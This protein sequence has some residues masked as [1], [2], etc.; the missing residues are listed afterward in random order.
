MK[1][2]FTLFFDQLQQRWKRPSTYF[3]LAIFLLLQGS[4][5]FYQ[6]QAVNHTAP[7]TLQNFLEGFW[8]PA[9]VVLP[10]IIAQISPPNPEKEASGCVFSKTSLLISFCVSYLLYMI[11]W[12]LSFLL[13]YC[14]NI[15]L[16]QPEN[17]FSHEI[18]SNGILF[19]LSSSFW[20]VSIGILARTLTFHKTLAGMLTFCFLFILFASTYIGSEWK[21]FQRTDS[22]FGNVFETLDECLQQWVDARAIAFHLLCGGGC[23]LLA[24]VFS[25]HAFFTTK[26]P[27]ST[28]RNGKLQVFL[29]LLLFIGIP[30]T[31]QDFPASIQTFGSSNTTLPTGT[32]AFLQSL[33]QP[34]MVYVLSPSQTLPKNFYHRLYR[35]FHKLQKISYKPMVW[36]VTILETTQSSLQW[37]LQKHYHLEETSGVLFVIGEKSLLLPFTVANQLDEE[38][39]LQTITT[40]QQP[41]EEPKTPIVV[42]IQPSDFQT[43]LVGFSLLPIV[44]L[45]TGIS[46]VVIRKK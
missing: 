19:L 46:L 13:P 1:S 2:F 35:Y 44:F 32:Q 10:G 23:L 28:Q 34:I 12:S 39:F 6:L 18:V 30:I 22:A 24:A 11:F 38:S 27:S 9:L 7:F 36:K 45:L 8:L 16:G 25:K 4:F 26:P 37:M 29:L 5:L 40:F 33:P 21:F 17:L 42:S 15:V 20:F 3:L 41:S 14:T 43:L 31:L